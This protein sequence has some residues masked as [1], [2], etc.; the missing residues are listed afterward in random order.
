[1]LQLKKDTIFELRETQVNCTVKRC[2]T[3]Y[4]LRFQYT[5]KDNQE[6]KIQILQKS[7]TYVQLNY[8]AAILHGTQ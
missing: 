8:F 4:I 5:G 2:A 3:A 1:M 6:W 7:G